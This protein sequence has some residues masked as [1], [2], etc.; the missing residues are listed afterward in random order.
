MKKVLLSVLIL[1]N[2]ALVS[3]AQIPSVEVQDIKGN[4]VETSLL[5]D[6]KT[7]CVISFWAVTCRPCIHELDVL[8]EC[9]EDWKEEMD[10]RIVTIS[11]DDIRFNAK[12]KSLIAGH[13]W[14]LF[15]HYFDINGD[16]KR[17]MGVSFTPQVFVLDKEGKIVY[18]HSGENP[19]IEEEIYEV[20]KKLQ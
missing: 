11:T 18:S 17:A 3:K 4:K 8:N 7:P 15:E 20:L 13:G 10:F 6:A 19:G 1:C 9:I 2:L 5:V 12:A 14:D 16:F